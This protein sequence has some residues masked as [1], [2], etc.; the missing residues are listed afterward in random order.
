VI[1]LLDHSR[2][3]AG[4]AVRGVARAGAWSAT[5]STGIVKG[6]SA[7]LEQKRRPRVDVLGALAE[8]AKY[9]VVTNRMGA[10]AVLSDEEQRLVR[11]GTPHRKVHQAG[12]EL[13]EEGDVSPR[14]MFIMS[15]WAC[16]LRVLP[17]GRTQIVG[18]L[19]P[20]DAIGLRGAAEPLSPTTISALTTM[21]TVDAAPLLQLAQ[22]QQ[23]FPG[24]LHALRRMSAQQEE[25]LMNQVTR[26]GALPPDAR[27]AHLLLEL[28][29]R[30]EQA[31]LA[32]DD[33]F[34]MPLT[35]ETLADTTALKTKQVGNI[36]KMLRARGLV[37]RRYEKVEL[38]NGER[39]RQLSGFRA[40]DTS[41]CGRF[42]MVPA[43]VSQTGGGPQIASRMTALPS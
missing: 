12:S 18:L 9:G 43:Q 3:A 4:L 6:L 22:D 8:A 37:R 42:R 35:N 2:A 40:P 14:P 38:L 27:V 31:G 24:V 10:I 26:L 5:T 16:R 32:S 13:A 41:S 34:V 25:F 19:L 11:N 23:Q 21:E 20:G 36:M 17:N 1:R 29:W 39:M 7:W 28:R 33:Q 30:L 15:G